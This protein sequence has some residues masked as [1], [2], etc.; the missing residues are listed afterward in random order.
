MRTLI[1]AS[2]GLAGAS[3]VC[4]F[5]ESAGSSAAAQNTTAAAQAV[6]TTIVR[7][8]ISGMTCATCPVTARVAL[9]KL[10]GVYDA[11]VTYDDSLGVVRYD[12]RRV[13]PAQIASHLT[14]LTGY[15]ATVLPDSAKGAHKPGLR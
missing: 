2:V 15:K 12:A 9:K 3:V 5:C 6:D 11:T 4:P 14:R 1:A 13:N 8:R 10:D 7:M